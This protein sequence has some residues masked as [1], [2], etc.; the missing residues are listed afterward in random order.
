VKNINFNDLFCFFGILVGY[1]SLLLIS[2]AFELRF[3]DKEVTAWG[4]LA[5]LKRMLDQ[6]G[7]TA[8]LQ[9]SG[10]PQPLSNRG[11]DP[12][13]L[14]TQFML[15]VWCGANRFEHGEVTRHD[16][17]IGELFGF[18]EWLTSKPCA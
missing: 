16:P 12:A 3:N 14:M 17:V 7:F 5:L 13:Q 1:V 4:G 2:M 15:S 8:A 6:L 9:N 10:L 18:H 11:Y